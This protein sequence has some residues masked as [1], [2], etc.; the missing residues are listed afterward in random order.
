VRVGA[1][2]IVHDNVVLGSDVTVE[3]HCEIGHPTPLAEGRPL[4]IGDGALIRSYS[5]FYEGSTF[6]PGL[7]TG[8]RVTVRELLTAGPGLQIGTLSDFQGHAELGDYVRTH[9]NVHI[10][11]H[12]TVGSYVWI[13]PYTV[14]TNDPHPPSE[15]MRGV[16]LEDYSVV[17]TMSVILP[18]VRVGTR[19]L[20]AAHSCVGK[21]VAPDT[22]V[23]GSPA[24]YLCDTSRVKL[25]DGS[26]RSAYPWMR[27]FHRGYPPEVVERW[28]HEFSAKDE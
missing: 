9:S 6:G 2:S 23:G 13:F 16:V 4:I 8:H 15:T 20:V 14:L 11:Q 10:G 12:S 22:V 21:D 27:H 25:R 3:S 24:K 5:C 19:S 26:G 1:F 7:K 18:G 17:A 28:K